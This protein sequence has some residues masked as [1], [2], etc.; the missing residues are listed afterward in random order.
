MENKKILSNYGKAN[1]TMY[2][3]KK[4]VQCPF[5][6]RVVF[7]VRDDT[8]IKNLLYYCKRSN[9]KRTMLINVEPNEP[10]KKD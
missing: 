2:Q 5:C 6:H 10:I 7:P 8:V 1:L 9:C 3:G 4:W